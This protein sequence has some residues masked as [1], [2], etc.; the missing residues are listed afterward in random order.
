VPLPPLRWITALADP[1]LASS[2][3]SFTG[4]F[5]APAGFFLA[6]AVVGLVIARALAWRGHDMGLLAPLAIGLGPVMVAVAWDVLERDRHVQPLRL[7]PGVD[8]E[9]SVDVLVW[10][11]GG[12]DQVAAVVPDIRRRAG[13][14]RSLTF[15]RAVPYE[16]LDEGPD[17]PSSGR[18]EERARESTGPGGERDRRP[19]R[20]PRTDRH[21]HGHVQIR[22]TSSPRPLRPRGGDELRP[23]RGS[24]C[25]RGTVSAP[26]RCWYRRRLVRREVWSASACRPPGT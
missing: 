12:S 21:R 16:W 14:I 4:S 22:I 10:V 2:I 23:G 1:L 19:G 24:R 7:D 25:D 13:E 9:G 15:A 5:V 26:R 20:L 11:Q 18:R 8:R 3:G 17:G 6:W